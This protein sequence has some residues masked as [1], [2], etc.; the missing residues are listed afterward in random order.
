MLRKN[1]DGSMSFFPNGVFRKGY[2]IRGKENQQK[3][4]DARKKQ[5]LQILLIV[6][7]ALVF[8]AVSFSFP[9]FSKNKVMI[10]LTLLVIPFLYSHSL[11]VREVE[12]MAE[13]EVFASPQEKKKRAIVVLALIAFIII[14]SKYRDQKIAELKTI[15]TQPTSSQ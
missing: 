10:A 7:T 11:L 15:Q 6:A 1:E 5:L 9:A 3:I 8:S 4:K 14:N 12:E 2:L 13:S